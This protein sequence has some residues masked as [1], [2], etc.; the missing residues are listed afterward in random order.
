M[1]FVSIKYAEELTRAARGVLAG[2]DNRSDLRDQM[3]DVSLASHFTRR[4]AVLAA[5]TPVEIREIAE[6]DIIG[7]GADSGLVGV[8]IAEHPVC[9]RQTLA[10]QIFGERRPLG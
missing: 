5:E 1:Q 3:S 6:P 9:A 2:R 7:D 10:D 4:V 8:R